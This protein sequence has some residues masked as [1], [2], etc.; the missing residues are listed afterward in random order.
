CGHFAD[1]RQGAAKLGQYGELVLIA[2]LIPARM[3]AVLLAA[4]AVAACRQ[5]V[6]VFMWRDPDLFPCGWEADRFDPLAQLT[7]LDALAAGVE[8]AE[9]SSAALARQPRSIGRN[10]AQVGF[11]QQLGYIGNH[12]FR[13]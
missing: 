5:N 2:H 1:L 8:I 7:I 12:R 10:I 13:F 9:A 4:F 3:I 11:I 6:S